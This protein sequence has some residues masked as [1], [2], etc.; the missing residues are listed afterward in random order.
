MDAA[1]VVQ[2]EARIA[3]LLAIREAY[4][5]WNGSV[6]KET[7]KQIEDIMAAAAKA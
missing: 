4:K 5:A 6:P 2:D 3:C 1:P 7:R